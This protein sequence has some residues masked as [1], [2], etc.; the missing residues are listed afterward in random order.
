MDQDRLAYLFSKYL[1]N[2][3]SKTELAD[4][5]RRIKKEDDA[6]LDDIID[7]LGYAG[8][9]PLGLLQDD[10][11]QNK[12]Y[13][14]I[15]EQIMGEPLV[16]RSRFFNLKKTILF[17]ASV[18]LI[19][20]IGL[21]FLQRQFDNAQVLSD[22]DIQLPEGQQAVIILE[23]GSSL[24]LMK[25]DKKLLDREGI[26][27]VL[28]ATG[29]VTFR[30]N[31]RD[32]KHTKNHTF[33]SPKGTS[34]VVI[35]SDGTKV[36]LNSGSKITYPTVFSSQQR[37]VTLDGEAYF[38]VQHN[39]LQPFIVSSGRTA[40]RVLGTEFNVA[41]NI[42]T[43]KIFTTLVSGSVEVHTAN[44][45]ELLKPNMQS[46]TH[47][48]SDQIE[49][50]E[51]ELREV[52]AWKEGYFR[53]KND[54]IKVVLNKIKTWYDIDGFE[55]KNYTQD[56]FTGSIVRTRKLSELLGQLEKISNYKFRI[57]EGR[58]IVMN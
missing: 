49:T 41:T 25:S 30:I 26:Q 57:E 40:I 17:A 42:E 43:D 31:T 11:D 20:S 24:D 13:E 18:L 44:N 27:L 23:D 21:F 15:R 55:I 19:V 45:M 6:I 8:K 2:T 7:R 58:V 5:L 48:F 32:G 9:E 53:F 35:L 1:Q 47:T 54:D 10:F 16:R 37:A 29:E 56:R 4:L 3:I 33:L 12:N 36:W 51:I 34:S 50:R 14:R 22:N 38:E 28:S 39:P 52:L 46:V